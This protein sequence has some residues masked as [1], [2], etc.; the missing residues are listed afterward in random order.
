V[1]VAVTPALG[2]TSAPVVQVATQF[3]LTSAMEVAG[4]AAIAAPLISQLT[5]PAGFTGESA[6]AT[7]FAVNV[8]V[9]PAVTAPEGEPVMLSVAGRAFTVWVIDELVGLAL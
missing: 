8:T 7:S 3:P 2:T 4:Q 5:V 1:Y 6:E 9:V